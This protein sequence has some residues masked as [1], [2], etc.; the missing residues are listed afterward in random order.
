[1]AYQF[2]NL[3]QL[4]AVNTHCHHL[5][6]EQQAAMGLADILA[7]SYVSFEWCGVNTPTCAAEFDAWHA[8]LGGRSYYH[9]LTNAMQK[10]YG[11]D[12][13]LCAKTWDAYDARAKE[14][15]ADPNWHV[16]VLK[17]DCHYHAVMLD[18]YWNPGCDNGHGELLR[19]SLRV[20]PFLFGYNN[21]AGDH[22]DTNAQR[23][24]TDHFIDDMDEY[25]A[26]LYRTVEDFL[27][28]GAVSLKLP[29]AYD[30]TLE[31]TAPTKEQAQKVF[32]DAT[33]ENIRNFQDYMFQKICE[34][35]AHFDVPL[36]IH[37]GL[38]KL[39]HSNAMGLR[40]L[41][42]ANPDTKFVIF[43][44]SYPWMDDFCGLAHNCPN[45]YP[46]ICWL[47]LIS[48]T[49]AIRTLDELM[50]V[51]NMDRV[52]W[53]CD[54]WTSEESYGARL[55]G[56]YV[57]QTAAAKKVAD[58]MWDRETADRFVRAIFHDNAKRLY[59]V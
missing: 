54:T 47:P 11:M 37:T 36:Q 23:L 35:A 27:V 16:K 5:P 38:G 31:I 48:P 12:E 24:Y 4:T 13:P 14:C 26:L 50:D 32:R 25:E 1:M 42:Y 2:E 15:H 46:D 17:E 28:K 49:A 21:T 58:G 7:H 18:T 6:D 19:P 10:L 29:T 39:S 57:I 9:W 3:S 40:D 53:G 33:P 44:G 59:K 52:C 30:R 8:K 20:N 45:V 56:E 51:C 55:A 22:N 41:I 43:H 34:A